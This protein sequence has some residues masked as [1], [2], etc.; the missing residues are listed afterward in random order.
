MP[1]PVSTFSPITPFTPASGSHSTSGYFDRPTTTTNLGRQLSIRPALCKGR[2]SSTSSSR[3]S[4]ISRTSE[5]LRP[6]TENGWKIASRMREEAW[7]AWEEQFKLLEANMSNNVPLSSAALK[8]S[9]KGVSGCAYSPSEKQPVQSRLT[10][11]DFFNDIPQ[12]TRPPLKWII[13]GHSAASVSVHSDT[14]IEKVKH[15]KLEKMSKS[16][17]CVTGEN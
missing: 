8:L 16:F 5:G 11:A 2:V 3:L 10:P 7:S 12:S 15:P 9:P 1:T 14:S 4:V 6:P 13:S 17:D